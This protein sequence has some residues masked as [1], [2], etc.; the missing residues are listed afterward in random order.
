M[1]ILKD[2]KGRLIVNRLYNKQNS[3]NHNWTIIGLD[4]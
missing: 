4:V 1:S 2:P 3:R